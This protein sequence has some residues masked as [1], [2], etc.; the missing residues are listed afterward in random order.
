MKFCM[1]RFTSWTGF[2]AGTLYQLCP[3]LEVGANQ[4]VSPRE[5]LAHASYSAE[6]TAAMRQA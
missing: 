2:S 1:F 3:L 4:T 5:E 6:Y